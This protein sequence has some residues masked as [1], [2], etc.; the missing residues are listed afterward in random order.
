MNFLED[1]EFNWLTNCL[2]NKMKMN[3]AKGLG[4]NVRKAEPLKSHHLNK[5]WDRGFLSHDNP[6]KLTDTL[7]FLIGITFYGILVSIVNFTWSA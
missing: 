7:L 3:A 4:N 6:Y 5:L 1:P 2:D